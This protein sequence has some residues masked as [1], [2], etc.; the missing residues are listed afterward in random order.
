MSQLLTISQ[1]TQRGLPIL[2]NKLAL[3]R[4]IN[5]QYS[6]EFAVAG[7]KIGNTVNVRVPPRYTV[8]EGPA[9]DLQDSVETFVPVTLTNQ[10][11]VDIP[12][13]SIDWTLS[14]DDAQK[15]FI[16]P[17]M[18]TLA[19]RIDYGAA[20]ILYAKVANHLGTVGGLAGLTTTQAAAQYVAAAKARL[21]ELG[22]PDTDD[23]SFIVSP[24]A[25]TYLVSLFTNLF[26]PAGTISRIFSRGAMG[27]N[28][29]GF[30]FAATANVPTH[31]YGTYVQGTSSAASVS[32]AYSGN[33]GPGTDRTASY[34][35]TAQAAGASTVTLTAGTTVT[36]ANVFE[37]NPQTRASTGTLKQFVLTSNFTFNGTNPVT[38][39]IWPAPVFS[40]QFQ[41]A[42]SATGTIA[43]GAAITA[44]TVTASQQVQQNL[45]FHPSA[46]TLVTADLELVQDGA[47]SSRA[48]WEGIS[49]R[50]LKTYL[51]S[52]DQM[53][54]RIDVLWGVQATYPEMAVRVTN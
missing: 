51:P 18:E 21:I 10:S 14:V 7:A 49:M 17:A 52:A 46:F 40:G 50:V 35:I 1:I 20:Q 29:L 2:K 54:L 33:T 3:S 36:F 38:M 11:H 24:T 19:N 37:V 26:N 45:A 42:Y 34:A 31:T 47:T 8:S 5:T 23:L 32:A 41:N 48:N 9:L 16:E 43:S 22:A 28:I 39:N 13:S 25:Q 27:D 4:A 30:N 12:W 6:S 15:R 44:P 53:G